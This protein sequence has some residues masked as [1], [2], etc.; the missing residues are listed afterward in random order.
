MDI[1]GKHDRMNGDTLVFILSICSV[2][3]SGLEEEKG[4]EGGDKGTGVQRREEV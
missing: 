1:S 4:R 2:C 3:S